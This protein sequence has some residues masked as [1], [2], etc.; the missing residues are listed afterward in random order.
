VPLGI[1]TAIAIGASTIASVLAVAAVRLRRRAWR[2]A[3]QVRA[4]G[5]PRRRLLHRL[6]LRPGELPPETNWSADDALLAWLADE[7]A[8]RRPAAAVDLGS[9]RSTLVMARAFALLGQPDIAAV[10]AATAVA[11]GGRA[12]DFVLQ[13]NIMGVLGDLDAAQ[14]AFSAALQAPPGPAPDSDL[15]EARKGLDEV[16]RHRQDR[17]QSPVA[18]DP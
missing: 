5:K 15:A 13:G 7:I 8:E 18:P 9:G 10:W 4:A 14:A 6:G 11:R 16:V 17:Q 3:R 12:Q 2:L 1:S